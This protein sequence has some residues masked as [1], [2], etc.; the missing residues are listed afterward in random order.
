MAKAKTVKGRTEKPALKVMHYIRKD[1]NGN[2]IYSSKTL[3]K[4]REAV[5][6][7]VQ[8]A[9]EEHGHKVPKAK[10]VK[11]KKLKDTELSELDRKILHALDALGVRD[12]RSTE[13]LHDQG[14]W[15]VLPETMDPRG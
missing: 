2:T 3:P 9:A 8:Q 6:A 4:L 12:G 13:L 10:D 14:H 7:D 15:L 1:E 5:G 11:T